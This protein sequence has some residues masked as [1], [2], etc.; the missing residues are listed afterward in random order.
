[1]LSSSALQIHRNLFAKHGVRVH[2]T[3]VK[4]GTGAMLAQLKAGTHDM[5]LALTEGIVAGIVYERLYD[6]TTL[7]GSNAI[8]F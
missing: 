7:P 3:D 2:W 4:E 1:V 5:V 6:R 8:V